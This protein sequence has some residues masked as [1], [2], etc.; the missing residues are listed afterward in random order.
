MPTKEEAVLL[1]YRRYQERS[2]VTKCLDQYGNIVKTV[3]AKDWVY[4]SLQEQE[5]WR[6]A[7][8]PFTQELSWTK[9]S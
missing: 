2:P 3:R 8:E 1:A 9:S 4:L 5:A 6:Y 7:L